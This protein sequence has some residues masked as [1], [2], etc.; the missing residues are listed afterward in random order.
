MRFALVAVLGLCPLTGLLSA[1]EKPKPASSEKPKA[2]PA[3]TVD[4][5]AMEA[6]VRHL[7]AVIPDV[8]VKIDDPKP[9][10]V[11]G[12]REVDVHFTYGARTQDETFY[13]TPDG[14]NMVR[15]LIYD[16]AKNPFQADLDKLKTDLS[17]SYGTPGAPVVL[18]IFADFQCPECKLEAASLRE[19]LLTTFP[20]QVRVY[21]K[22]LPLEQIHPWA[23]PAAIAGRCVFQQN[24]AS[25]WNYFDW[26]Y[27]HQDGIGPDNLKSQVLEFAKTAPEID[28][29]QLGRCLDTKA[30]EEIG[31]AHV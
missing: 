22:D 13:V 16:L 10:A 17:P 28:G 20:T 2:A 8:E 23:K 6:Y 24:A 11:A 15:G 18:V 14:K 27:Q 26:I 5:V 29:L 25:F 3:S 7:L 19:N 12:L 31:R 4:K 1:Q 30:T 21:F 9:S